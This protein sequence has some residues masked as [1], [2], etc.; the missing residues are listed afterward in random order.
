[1]DLS[2]HTPPR[3]ARGYNLVDFGITSTSRHWAISSTSSFVGFSLVLVI[4][5]HDSALHCTAS[6]SRFNF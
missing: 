6:L 5:W 2:P 1:M 4:T 3:L